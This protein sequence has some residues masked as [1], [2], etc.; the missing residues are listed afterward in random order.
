MVHQRH[1]R[2][3]PCRG[4]YTAA[5]QR[6]RPARVGRDTARLD[7]HAR[8]PS[9]ATLAGGA[10]IG[11][12]ALFGLASGLTWGAGDFAGGLIGRHASALLAV[13]VS[14]S[15]SVLGILLLLG[16]TGEAA[17][18]QASLWWA[19]AAGASGVIGVGCFYY[20]LSRGTMGII[21]P[22]AAV[23]GAGVPVLFDLYGGGALP[24]LRLIG[25]AIA[26][27]AVV[28]ISMPA[29]TKSTDVRRSQ[30]IDLAELPF[31]IGSGLGFAFFFLFID[32]ASADGGV[33]WPLATARVAGLG[34][35][36]LF[37]GALLVRGSGSWRSRGER[38]LGLDRLRASKPNRLAAV[39]V[40]LT[41][42]L[43]ELGG[44]A[45]FVFAT[46]SGDFAVAV[47]LASLYPVVT[48]LLAALF[49]RERLTRLQLVGVML[50]TVSVILLR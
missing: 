12:G 48:T 35:L 10:L 50:A 40:V 5:W 3:D 32:Q 27:V 20:A 31:V 19:A 11:P 46:Q 15:I 7:G 9:C 29:G 22:L 49:L 45:F 17:P 47:I 25:I 37:V 33:W 41:A 13:V 4:Y 44:N 2:G 6:H 34:M 39:A 38:T 28:L 24:D 36:G 26:L 30:R 1:R 23:I 14:Y 8:D 43:G 16:I 42:G 21:A 18:S